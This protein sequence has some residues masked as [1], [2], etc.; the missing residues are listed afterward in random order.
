MKKPFDFVILLAPCMLWLVASSLLGDE[1]SLPNRLV[2]AI[3]CTGIGAAALLTKR[4]A[5]G[6]ISLLGGLAM[7]ASVPITHEVPAATY[8]LSMQKIEV[9]AYKTSLET[10][11]PDAAQN[12]ADVVALSS[13]G[14][15]AAEMPAMPNHPFAYQSCENAGTQIFAR[16]PMHNVLEAERMGATQVKGELEINKQRIAFAVLDLSAAQ[17]EGETLALLSEF[18]EEKGQPGI[19]VI[20]TGKSGSKY[21]LEYLAHTSGY[22]KSKVL[23]RAFGSNFGLWEDPSPIVFMHSAAFTCDAF[24]IEKQHNAN[25]SAR[26]HLEI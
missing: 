4:K 10:W 24:E 20:D 17:N 26:Y 25:C 23:G 19:A 22:S 9:P 18:L 15:D 11:K 8:G 16:Y 2:L 12:N 13:K 1:F 7:L 21:P 14:K 5:A 6:L 3:L